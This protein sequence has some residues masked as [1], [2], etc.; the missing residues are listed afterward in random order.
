MAEDR[1]N[2]LKKWPQLK[3]LFDRNLEV[4]GNREHI[5]NEDG[6]VST[7]RSMGVNDPLLN[8]GKPTLIPSIWDGKQRDEHEAIIRAIQYSQH[9]KIKWPSFKD[10]KESTEAAKAASALMQTQ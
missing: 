1:E 4:L 8:D 6:T 7:I 10:H 2:L 3:S 5:L 9:R